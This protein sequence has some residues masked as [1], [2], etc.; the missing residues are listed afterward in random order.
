MR[1]TEKEEA[2]EKEKEPEIGNEV[3][4]IGS[5]PLDSAS[6]TRDLM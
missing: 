3:T 6:S 2:K 1:Q 4:Y 5:R